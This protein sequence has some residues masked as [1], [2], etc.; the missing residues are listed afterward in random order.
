MTFS[1]AIRRNRG[2][3]L[4]AFYGFVGLLLIGWGAA[5]LQSDQPGYRNVWGGLVSAPF[6]IVL[7]LVLIALVTGRPSYFAQ[8]AKWPPQKGSSKQSRI[9]KKGPSA[10]R[11][12]RPSA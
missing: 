3:V 10:P 9:E 2:K 8:P 5:A 7:G 12:D 4:R 1:R 11:E 6:A